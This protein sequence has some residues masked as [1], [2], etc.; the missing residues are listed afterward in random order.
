MTNDWLE[1]Y[2][3]LLGIKGRQPTLETL[4]ELARAHRRVVFANGPSLIRKAA[5]RDGPVPAL[6]TDATLGAWQQQGPGG[7][8][9][10]IATMAG[11]L[12]AGLGFESHVV[13]GSIDGPRAHQANVVTV[14]GRR[15]LLDLGNGAP[16]FEPIPIDEGPQ[17]IDY[18]GLGYRFDRQGPDEQ[19]VQSRHIEGEWRPFALY[20]NEAATPA[21]RVEAFQHHH[22][23]P[24][25][26]FVMST[27]T[28]VQTREAEVL[29]L[30]DHTFTHY[31]PSGKTSRVV[32][33][34][35]AYR[36]L[37]QDGFGLSEFPLDEALA[38]WSRITGATI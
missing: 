24:A 5:T 8:C 32:E 29:A 14:D 3:D 31:K 2:L 12:L 33:G 18:A 38:A 23:L 26:S 7:V 6:D 21:Q 16:L 34:V 35:D 37:V 15:F 11:D 10:E 36:G 1:R 4:T 20:E 9:Y 28:L 30:R 27:F 13:L 19:L 17:E 22:T 25:R